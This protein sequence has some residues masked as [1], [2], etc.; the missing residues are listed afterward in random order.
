[1]QSC[2]AHPKPDCANTDRAA[3]DKDFPKGAVADYKLDFVRSA[4]L[5]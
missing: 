1:M 5:E 4:G 2:E 3:R